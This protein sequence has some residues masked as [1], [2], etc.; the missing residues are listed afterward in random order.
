MWRADPTV[1]ES[2]RS[3]RCSPPHR[4]GRQGGH[5]MAPGTALTT[6]TKLSTQRRTMFW[7][8]GHGPA[9]GRWV[10]DSARREGRNDHRPQSNRQNTDKMDAL[11]QEIEDLHQMIKSYA[12]EYQ[13]ASTERRRVLGQ[14]ISVSTE[15][16]NRLW[17][18]KK[19]YHRGMSLKLTSLP[20]PYRFPYV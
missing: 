15:A 17:D 19:A 3:P 11:D 20:T 2:P 10:D 4:Q 5:H 12:T 13:T 18:R 8:S 16:L 6:K 9:S 7:G 14:A 1:T